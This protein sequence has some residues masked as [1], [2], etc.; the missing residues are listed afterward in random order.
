MKEYETMIKKAGKGDLQNVAALAFE[1]WGAHT[2]DELVSEFFKL[3]NDPQNALVLLFE[4]QNQPIGF[5]QCQLRHDYV[6]GTDSSPVGYLEGI[7][8]KEQYRGRGYAKALL[9]RCEQWAAQKGCSEFASDCQITNSQSINFHMHTG[10]KQ[11]AKIV[12]FTK[13]IK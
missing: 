4:L 5:A 8:I 11:A 1:M 12:C 3:I 6:E 9:K 2:Q 10:F 7:F 13:K